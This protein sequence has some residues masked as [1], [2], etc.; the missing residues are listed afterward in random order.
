MKTANDTGKDYDYSTLILERKDF[1]VSLKE[2]EDIRKF[3]YKL[4][5]MRFNVILIPKEEIDKF[6]D[7]DL[8]KS[9]LPFLHSYLHIVADQSKGYELLDKSLIGY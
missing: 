9:I 2:E 1:L 7:T 3:N 6:K 8:L 5:G 4:R